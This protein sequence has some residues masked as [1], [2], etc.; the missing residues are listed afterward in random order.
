MAAL[1]RSITVLLLALVMAISGGSTA[2]AHADYESSSPDDGTTVASPPQE[3]W[4]E[5]TEPPMDGSYLLVYDPCGERV[6]N[7]SYSYLGKR[8]TV[9]VAAD[10][11]GAYTVQWRVQSELDGH[12]TAGDFGFTVTGGEACPSDEPED[13]GGK[14]ENEGTGGGGSGDAGGASGGDTS[15]QG[16]EAGAA[17]QAGQAEEK[18]GK[19]AAKKQKNDSK[20]DRHSKRQ[21]NERKD[22]EPPEEDRTIE[23]VS[24][25]DPV[26]GEPTGSLPLGWLL[27]SFSLAALI[28]AV[29]GQIYVNLTGAP[30]G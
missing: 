19:D 3:V 29:G 10:K 1:K 20:H 11:A 2:F 9:G 18:P 21:R 4:A 17:E 30:R 16:D 23:L 14:D 25:G 28:G 26:S 12:P 27:I 5:F 8:I 7:G 6:D 24:G 15:D 22:R 13:D